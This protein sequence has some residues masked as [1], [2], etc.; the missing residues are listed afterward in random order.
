MLRAGKPRKVYVLRLVVEGA[1]DFPVDMLRYDS[2]VPFEEKE[3][4]EI[5]QGDGLRLRK[6][7]VVLRRFSTSGMPATEGRWK[8]FGWNVV[9]EAPVE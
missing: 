1:G 7:Q 2:C 9:S 5:G 4:M 3:S 6:R 8:S